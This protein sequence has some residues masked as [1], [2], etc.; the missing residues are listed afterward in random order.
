[1]AARKSYVWTALVIVLT[2]LLVAT[3]GGTQPIAGDTPPPACAIGHF[4]TITLC[5]SGGACPVPVPCPGGGQCSRWDYQFAWHDV[6]PSAALVSVAAD[7]GIRA[8]SPTGIITAP[9]QT[10][11]TFKVGAND[12]GQRWV[13]FTSHAQ[14]FNA[15]ITTD[16]AEPVAGT[17]GG[18][19]GNKVGFCQIQTPGKES[20][21]PNAAVPTAVVESLACGTVQ[22]NIDSKGYTTSI[23]PLTGTCTVSTDTLTTGSNQPT[24]F[25]DPNTRI[26]FQGSKRYCWPNSFGGMIC[27]P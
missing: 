25:V 23:T 17:A 11:S 18:K 24:L 1:M 20:L 3:P 16:L 9:G 10:E 12:F 7:I 19:A 27:A 26:T 8:L 13:R 5:P 4:L 6:N 2:T 21:D 15:S 22:R 14:T